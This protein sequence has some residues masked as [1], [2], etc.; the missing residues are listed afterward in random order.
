V[1]KGLVGFILQVFL[2][3][4]RKFTLDKRTIGRSA[5]GPCR[6]RQRSHHRGAELCQRDAQRWCD[7]M[8]QVKSLLAP[9][10][11]QVF[12]SPS[13]RKWLEVSRYYSMALILTIG[14]PPWAPPCVSTLWA[15]YDDCA[16]ALRRTIRNV[17]FIKEICCNSDSSLHQHHPWRTRRCPRHLGVLAGSLFIIRHP[18]D[19]HLL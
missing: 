11:S 9:P 7:G 13:D 19:H 14:T 3:T 17:F 8:A 5:E 6:L 1:A 2:T 10:T 4:G 16:Q 18:L 15:D 12:A